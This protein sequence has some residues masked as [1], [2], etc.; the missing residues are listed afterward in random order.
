MARPSK[1]TLANRALNDARKKKKTMD[2]ESEEESE[3][4]ESPIVF[5]ELPILDSDN[6]EERPAQSNTDA[7]TLMNNITDQSYTHIPYQRTHQLSRQTLWRNQQRQN[8]LQAAAAGSR[9]IRSMFNNNVQTP[10]VVPNIE[11]SPSRGV[12]L[13]RAITELERFLGYNRASRRFEIPLNAQTRQRH[14]AVLHFLYL[15][16][17]N[18]T[19]SRRDLSLQVSQSFN[20]G[21]YFSESLVTWE[22]M[23]I[24]GEGIPE[25]RAGCHTKL[26]SL[27]D[28]EEVQL[29]VKDFISSKREEIT[30]SL[31]AQ[32]VTEFVGSHE[33][34]GSVQT[35]LELAETETDGFQQKPKSLKARAAENWLKK[36]GYSWRSGKKGVYIDG[37]EREDVVKYRQD[38][39]LPILQGVRSRLAE[40]DDDGNVMTE[41]GLAEGSRWVVIVTHDESTFHVN[42]GRRQMWLQDEENPL[43]PK[44]NGRGIMVSEFLTPWS[45]LQ[46]PASVSDHQLE[47]LQLQ[48]FATK[49]FEYGDN[50]YW[51]SEMLAE[52]TLKVAVPLFELAFPSDQFQGLFLFDNATS[53]KIMAP[54]AL[55]TRKMNLGPG[56]KQ[57]VMRDGWN[58][59][60][61]TRQAMN[62]IDGKPKGIRMILQERGLWPVGGIRLQCTKE[63]RKLDGSCC[64]RHLL[65]SQPDFSS[66]RGYLQEEIEKRGHLVA[67]YPK[68]HP[69]LNYIEYFWGY[70]KRFA[71][72]N[73]DY[74]LVGLRTTTPRA[75]TAVPKETIHR[76]FQKS[77]R[78]A[79]AYG[80]G[81]KYG[82]KEFSNRVYKSH[83]R[84]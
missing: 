45:R 58:S 1:R 35:S 13:T 41:K 2:L 47:A 79:D 43:R 19:A 72:E 4:E 57:P 66:Q 9:D 23:W 64:A 8:A 15:Q 26:S 74:T 20:R 78:I 51:N 16:R 54:D 44:G 49:T 50:Q 3:I 38:V 34:G 62:D 61:N 59:L 14:R 27:F 77:V 60:T 82:T 55:D 73:C 69:E 5:P 28:D 53:H 56:G 17:K 42:D 7:F 70:C 6:A 75:L 68:Y 40:W 65:G 71:R 52:Q 36:M 29:F 12:I 81:H 39:F 83:R 10:K 25:G 80:E 37:H 67:Y 33:M 76:F 84:V 18:P 31:L 24:R 11:T 63:A 30:A 21:K 48:R 46:A 22:R 32:A